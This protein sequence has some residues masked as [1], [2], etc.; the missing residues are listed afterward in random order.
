MN[1][2]DNKVWKMHMRGESPNFEGEFNGIQLP[3]KTHTH[4]LEIKR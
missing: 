3:L 2:L 4:A 1:F